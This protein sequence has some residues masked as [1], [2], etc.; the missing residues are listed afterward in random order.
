MMRDIRSM[1][2][3]ME[4]APSLDWHCETET[5]IDAQGKARQ[6]YRLDRFHIK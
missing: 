5:Y 6:M 3:R 2:K 1:I 4:A